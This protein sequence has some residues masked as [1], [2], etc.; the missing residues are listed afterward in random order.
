MTLGSL[1]EL[2]KLFTY[3]TIKMIR[4]SVEKLQMETM[5]PEGERLSQAEI[6][7]KHLFYTL[8]PMAVSYGERQILSDY[9]DFI[10]QANESPSTKAV[11]EKLAFLDCYSK[12]IRDHGFLVNNCDLL[13]STEGK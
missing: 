9:I 3:K 4:L 12:L 13:S 11:L 8:I 5:K 2:L 6:W 1:P 7:E 10:E